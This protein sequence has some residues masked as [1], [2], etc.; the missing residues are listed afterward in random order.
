MYVDSSPADTH[1]STGRDRNKNDWDR[2]CFFE[3]QFSCTFMFV[4]SWLSPL[5]VP[6]LHH[7]QGGPLPP[8]IAARLAHQTSP[9]CSSSSA[10]PLASMS[11]MYDSHYCIVS[12]WSVRSQVSTAEQYRCSSSLQQLHLAHFAHQRDDHNLKWKVRQRQFMRHPMQITATSP[13]HKERPCT[14]CLHVWKKICYFS[15]KNFMHLL[16]LYT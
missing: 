15:I 10:T 14:H 6:H 16:C 5:Q 11:G 2:D 1:Q 12:Q 7:L 13:P 9:H 3:I 4:V 8:P